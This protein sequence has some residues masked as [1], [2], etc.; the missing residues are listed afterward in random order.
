MKNIS[1]NKI[2]NIVLESLQETIIRKQVESIV[3]ESLKQVIENKLNEASFSSMGKMS[4]KSKQ[5]KHQQNNGIS[6]DDK[7]KQDKD[8]KLSNK[9]KSVMNMLK[10]TA[11][12]DAQLAYQL[13]NEDEYG[14]RDGQRSLFSKMKNGTPDADG[15]VRRF[16]PEEINKLYEL[17]RGIGK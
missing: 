17:I 2:K 16:S 9:Y 5:D 15:V 10:D 11:I 4:P 13:W 12:T 8:G 3:A 14:G 7:K 1:E 6:L